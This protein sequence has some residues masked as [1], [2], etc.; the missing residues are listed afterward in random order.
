MT[1]KPADALTL[2]AQIATCSPCH[3]SKRGVVIFNK[4]GVFAA[5]YNQPPGGAPCANAP[6]CR[7]ACG[8]VCVHAEQ[9]ALQHLLRVHDGAILGNWTMRRTEAHDDAMNH[10]MGDRRS[11]IVMARHDEPLSLLHV[12]VE[13]DKPVPSGPPSCWQCSREILHRGL[14]DRVYLL[15]GG[16]SVFS[17]PKLRSYTPQEFHAETMRH[18]GLPVLA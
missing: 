4:N 8:K 10:L 11:A 14:V 5:G 15:E 12:K 6:E 2:A 3:K 18:C 7:E 17:P 13:D 16:D 1:Y 9:D